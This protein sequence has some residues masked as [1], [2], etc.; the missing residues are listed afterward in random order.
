MKDKQTQLTITISEE[1]KKQLKIL[2]IER[3]MTVSQLLLERY[4]SKSET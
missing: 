1:L 2:A 4:E 3:G